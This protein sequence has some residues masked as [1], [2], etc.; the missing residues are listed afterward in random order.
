MRFAC[1]KFKFEDG[2]NWFGIALGGSIKKGQRQLNIQLDLWKYAV[3]FS[4]QQKGLK[5][6]KGV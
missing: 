6:K 4:V 3:V 1:N 5:F 2:V